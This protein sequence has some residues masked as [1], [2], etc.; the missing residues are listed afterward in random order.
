MR[1]CLESGYVTAHLNYWIDLIFGIYNRKDRG[2]EKMNLFSPYI[3]KNE[4]NKN[5]S[6]ENRK[7]K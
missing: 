1:R 7:S 6:K 2:L 5:L 3:Y 4:L